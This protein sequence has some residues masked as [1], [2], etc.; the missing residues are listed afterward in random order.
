MSNYVNYAT[1]LETKIVDFW[2][3]L[4]FVISGP[5]SAFAENRNLKSGSILKNFDLPLHCVK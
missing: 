3:S 5:G 4:R 1:G 2:T